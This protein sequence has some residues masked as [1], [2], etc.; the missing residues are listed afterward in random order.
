MGKGRGEEGTLRII[1]IQHTSILSK[2]PS[3][4]RKE[5]ISIYPSVVTILLFIRRRNKTYC[6]IICLFCFL[7]DSPFSD[8]I[9]FTK[10][11]QHTYIP[12]L[13]FNSIHEGKTSIHT[14]IHDPLSFIYFE[15][16]SRCPQRNLPHRTAPQEKPKIPC[17]GN[18][19][20][21]GGGCG[22]YDKET[23]YGGHYN[24]LLYFYTVCR[25]LVCMI[26]AKTQRRRRCFQISG[27]FDL[28]GLQVGRQVKSLIRLALWAKLHEMR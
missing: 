19:D 25:K 8:S 22:V 15:P 14:Y 16:Q 3:M 27:G 6:F 20:I 13:W 26:H 12:L 11:N 24:I 10:E 18:R 1:T 4:F 2:T 5:A 7:N 17:P 23:K 9:Q 21:A 28:I